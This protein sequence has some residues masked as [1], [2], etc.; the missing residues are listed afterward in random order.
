MIGNIANLVKTASSFLQTGSC[1]PNT[2]KDLEEVMKKTNHLSSKKF[3][4]T[5]VSTILLCFF[6]FSSIAI[7]FVIPN[8]PELIAGYVTIF[9][10]SIEIFSI[11][12]A[13]YLGVQCFVDLKYGSTSSTSFDTSVVKEEITENLTNNHKEPD[14]TLE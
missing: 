2:P 11:I 9:T 8:V 3:F 14:Y 1:P 4:I 12:I 13:S 10:K 6:Y 5:M 7:L